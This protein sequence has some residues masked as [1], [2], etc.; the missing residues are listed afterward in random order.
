[1]GCG[2]RLGLCLPLACFVQVPSF[3]GG[4]GG[5]GGVVTANWSVDEESLLINTKKN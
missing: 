5:G 3:G 2:C 1:M 4:G